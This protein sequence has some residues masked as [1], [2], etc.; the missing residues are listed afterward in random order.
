MKVSIL[1]PKGAIWQGTARDLIL[2]TEDGEI[3][4]LDFHQPFLTRLTKGDIRLG[5]DKISIKDGVARMHA[6]ELVI[7]AET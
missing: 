1:E 4:V 6:N 7:L 2:P 5:T 3:C